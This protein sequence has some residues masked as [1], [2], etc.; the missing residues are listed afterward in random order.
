V[1]DRARASNDSAR[2][3]L[4]L[5][6]VTPSNETSHLVRSGSGVVAIFVGFFIVAVVAGGLLVARQ[7]ERLR[8]RALGFVSSVAEYRSSLL[9]PWLLERT[10]DALVAGHDQ[11]LARALE[12][13]PDGASADRTQEAAARLAVIAKAYGYTTIVALDADGR[14]RFA[15]GPVGP[16]DALAWRGAIRAAVSTRT[17][18]IIGLRGQGAAVPGL[19]FDV[20]APIV[21][22]GR[23]SETVAGAVVL[24]SDPSAPGGYVTRR[25]LDDILGIAP[26]ASPSGELSL[27]VGTGPDAL[28]VHPKRKEADGAWITRSP[29]STSRTA[30]A[31]LA[32][33]AT[34]LSGAIDETGAPVLV[35]VKDLPKFGAKL[36]G[37]IE[38][39]ELVGEGALALWLSVS[40]LGGL[41]LAVA[42]LA[43][44][45]WTRRARAALR[46]NEEKF[47]VI[48]ETMLDGYALSTIEGTILLVN[49]AMV[50]MLGYAR[51]SDLLGKNMPNDVFADAEERHRLR[52]QLL[53]GGQ[54]QGYKATFKRADGSPVIVEGNVRLIR[55]EDGTPLAVEGVV[56]DM[57]AHYQI[58][59][60]LIAAREAAVTA[61]RVKS[62]FL[63]NMSHEIRTPLNA[64]VGLGHL[65]LRA[66]LP[67]RERTYVSQIRSSA[68]MLLGTVEDV[69]DFSKIE[70]GRLEL[71]RIPFALDRLVADV[72]G[73]LSVQAEAKGVTLATSLHSDVPRAL[74]GD[75]LRLGQVLTNL[76]GN[77]LKFTNE[78][79]VV[80]EITLVEGDLEG[81][82]VRL[83]FAVH[84]TGIGVTPEQI[85]RIFEPFTQGDGSTTR[86]YGGT[87]L[88]LSIC[89][90]IV[91]A[92]GGRLEARS[93]PGRGSTFFFTVHLPICD[94]VAAPG[95]SR[96]RLAAPR[97]DGAVTT[98][99]VLR[100]VRVLVAE[101]NAINQEVAREILQ[102][103]GLVVTLVDDGRA[104][105]ER[106]VTDHEIEI[107][108][109]DVQ[110][111]RLD[112]LAA[113]REIRSHAELARLP[114]IAMTAYAL[115]AERDRCLA[116]GMNDY[117]A[118]PF[119]PAE[120]FDL[121]A[122]WVTHREGPD[123]AARAPQ[124]ADS[125]P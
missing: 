82:G 65:L 52:E 121:L 120:L 69:L 24:R 1:S 21:F 78:G 31:L 102:G 20:V 110:M 91:E 46:A 93:T 103:A 88:G 85:T 101:D 86:Q 63:A 104:A 76:A 94:G 119:E 48:F 73:V 66:D 11:I 96:A 29:S 30:E 62:Q 123:V 47:K 8:R 68:R 54:V 81:D 113:T 60:D 107:V 115:A 17:T 109:M 18:Q 27:I 87:G 33:G 71:E 106:A 10:G 77:A 59:S 72:V 112:G 34:D 26:G 5:G 79:Q 41:F 80:I 97:A 35:V 124:G 16:S 67:A 95:S 22:E 6:I 75:S 108:L 43:R 49:P 12:A 45:G 51:E 98:L 25:V 84:D 64:I 99:E 83:R 122:R 89:R 58:R 15:F 42:L 111:P 105:V 116:A 90:Q 9:E 92:M 3:A 23:G 2:L 118:K 38:T 125:A 32:R 70:A 39:N 50:R 14:R 114:I 53:T 4:T 100:G 7:R 74:V 19:T 56:R 117:V 28:F 37:Q 36:I 40:L 57:T 61:A 13:V 44:A 55:G